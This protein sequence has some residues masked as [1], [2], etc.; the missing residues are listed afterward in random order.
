[1]TDL[2]TAADKLVER[3]ET[4]DDHLV[5]ALAGATAMQALT[6]TFQKMR[7]QIVKLESDLTQRER[8]I[9]KLYND[10]QDLMRTVDHW[11]ERAKKAESGC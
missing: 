3:L 8:Q 6:T 9:H 7:D 4:D 11:R 5:M 10:K 2:N 1:M